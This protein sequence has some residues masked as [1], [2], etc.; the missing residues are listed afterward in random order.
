MHLHMKK[1][2]KTP[3]PSHPL[4]GELLAASI[5]WRMIL[6]RIKSVS[7]SLSPLGILSLP[8]SQPVSVWTL[9]AGTS[10]L[11]NCMHSSMALETSRRPAVDVI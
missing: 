1:K 10:V 3:P 9:D 5:S 11:Y 7:S 8:V 4:S 6:T 2:A